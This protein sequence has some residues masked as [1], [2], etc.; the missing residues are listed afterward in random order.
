MTNLK[1]SAAAYLLLGLVATG[2]L[3]LGF[4]IAST[5]PA[6]ADSDMVVDTDEEEAPDDDEADGV[7]DIGDGDGADSND[8][9]EESTDEGLTASRC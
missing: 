8:T 3:S 7:S 1:L 4:T 2:P 5:A 9:C 6:L